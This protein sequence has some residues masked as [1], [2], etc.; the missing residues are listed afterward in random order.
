M[1]SCST[2]SPC[3]CFIIKYIS[4]SHNY[5]MTLQLHHPIVSLYYCIFAPVQG[6]K[7]CVTIRSIKYWLARARLSVQPAQMSTIW[8]YWKLNSFARCFRSDLTDAWWP[9]SLG[10]GRASAAVRVTQSS[11]AWRRHGTETISRSQYTTWQHARIDRCHRRW[12]T[13]S[14]LRLQTGSRALLRSAPWR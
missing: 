8:K 7:A 14:R 6:H 10:S 3:F 12:S 2:I 4:R 1:S 5:A 9:A 13:S 11:A